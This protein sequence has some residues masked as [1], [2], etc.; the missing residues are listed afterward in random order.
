MSRFNRSAS[1][2]ITLVAIVS[3]TALAIQVLAASRSIKWEPEFEWDSSTDTWRVDGIKVV[4]GLL[5]AYFVSAATVGAVG[6][7]GVVKSKPSLV[8][9]YRDYSIADFSFCTF[10]TFASAYGAFRGSTRTGVCEEMSRQPEFLR[11]MGEMGLSL[12]NCERWF[13][14]AV[15]A[16][17]ACM[18]IVS[19]VR[20]HFLLAVSN[21]YNHLSRRS[22][23]P[24]HTR[25]PSR[26]E[27]LQR[28][29]ILPRSNSH[30]ASSPTVYAPVPLSELT[31]EL[32]QSAME[33]WVKKTDTHH[34][35]HK[36]SSSQSGRICLPVVPGEGLTPPPT[37]TEGKA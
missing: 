18:I 11:N 15:M 35:R 37:Y 24:T 16:F 32:R 2:V 4:W 28:I 26:Q 7:V 12:E 27:S 21:Y 14:R 29:F 13:E 34:S 1:F 9:F 30:S 10:A 19:V 5:L 31:P 6:F 8:R 20:L 17:V 22:V 25:N 23:L 3:N 33:A 36:S